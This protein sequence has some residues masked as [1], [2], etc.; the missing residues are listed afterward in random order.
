MAVSPVIADWLKRERIPYRAF[1]HPPA[2]TAL[3][4][5]AVSHVRARSALK[6]VILMADEVPMQAVL[7]A[8]YRVDF[9]VLRLAVGA[10]TLRLAAEPEI[11]ALYPDFEIGATP[12]FGSMFGHRV[13]VERAL[14]G[15][16]ELVFRAGTHTDA[17]VMHYLDFAEMVK[18]VVGVFGLAPGGGRRSVL[19]R[20][21]RKQ[22]S[23]ITDD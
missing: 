1:K 9:E 12:P 16:P 23:R 22:P 6:V 15:D 8:H 3:E 14:V 18:P 11:A 5:A 2:Y 19:A 13:F 17:I 4:H 21:Q 20:P 7:P 10:S